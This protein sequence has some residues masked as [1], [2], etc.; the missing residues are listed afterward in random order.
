MAQW[1]NLNWI[2]SFINYTQ[3]PFLFEKSEA[4]VLILLGLMTGWLTDEI[5]LNLKIFK[6]I[7]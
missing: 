7:Y 6:L 5:V 4:I 1:M 3:L 2:N